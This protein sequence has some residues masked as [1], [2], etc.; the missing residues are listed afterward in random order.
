MI[1]ADYTILGNKRITELK[2]LGK[3]SGTEEVILDNGDETYKITVD[4]LLGYI[5]K[6]INSGTIPPSVFASSTIIEIPEGESIPV[7]SRE[8]GNYYINIQDSRDV[9]ANTLYGRIRVSPNMGL[10][11][12]SD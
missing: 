9:A 5:A 10:K 12:V 1:M 6:Q 11:I 2:T 7:E 4:S 8:D 3:L